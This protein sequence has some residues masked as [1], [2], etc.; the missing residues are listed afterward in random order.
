LSDLLKSIAALLLLGVFL[1]VT[2]GSC[3]VISAVAVGLALKYCWPVLIIAPA[4]MMWW[5]LMDWIIGRMKR[6]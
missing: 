2:F 5:P 6:G 4:M 3:L 1:V